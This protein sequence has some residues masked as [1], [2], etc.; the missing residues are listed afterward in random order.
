MAE[1]E[2][3]DYYNDP[4]FNQPLGSQEDQPWNYPMPADTEDGGGNWL[5][6]I[7]SAIG[8]LAKQFGGPAATTIGSLLNAGRGSNAA[9]TAGGR[10]PTPSTGAS[11][12]KPRN[13]SSSS[14]TSP[15][16]FRPDAGV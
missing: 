4:M 7:L 9:R 10:K 13:G 6:S 1:Y 11:T 2:G 16:I 15:P 3:Y 12:C 8:P 14:K 5:S